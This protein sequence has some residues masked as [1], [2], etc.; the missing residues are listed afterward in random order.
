MRRKKPGFWSSLSLDGQLEALT[1]AKTFAGVVGGA[2]ALGE[3]YPDR[4]SA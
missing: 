1:G 2:Y 4:P 3:E